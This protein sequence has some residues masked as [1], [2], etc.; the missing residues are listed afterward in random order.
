MQKTVLSLIIIISIL[1]GGVYYFFGG[2]LGVDKTFITKSKINIGSQEFLDG[3][4]ISP[5]YTCNGENVSP[6]LSFDRI[7]G[8]T[9]SLVLIV[10]DPDAGTVPFNHWLVFNLNPSTSGIEEGQIPSALLGTND[11][12]ELKYMGPCPTGT[13]K[14]YFRI[15][16]LDTMLD[17]SEGV[18]R[19]EIDSAMKG[20]IIASGVLTGTF[21]R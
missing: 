16:A 13:H 21:S 20:H 11:F 6:P 9:K 10:D 7:P 18:K 15:Y 5:K 12:G 19:Q 1:I 3:E 4:I 17:L 8:D 2:K 14:Y